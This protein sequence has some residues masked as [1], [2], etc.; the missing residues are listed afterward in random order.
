[1]R[2][3]LIGFMAAG[4]T[5]VG[6][7]LAL[8]L[9]YSFLDLDRAVEARAGCS[10]GEIFAHGG[11]AAFRDLEHKCLR[12]AATLTDAV[13]GTGG[14]TM[15]FERNREVIRR[16]GTGVWLCPSLATL[17]ARL[18]RSSSQRPLYRSDEQAR[19][20]YND[21]ISAYRT[22]DLKVEPSS[23]DTPEDVAAKIAGLLRGKN[24][25]I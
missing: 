2:V 15:V 7:A 6:S 18:R 21:R 14:G 22:A 4:K 10:V 19:A 24:C 5:A 8:R 17:L 25:V 11:E 16:S 9:G 23:D 20:L 13:I 1:M 12:C 3:Y